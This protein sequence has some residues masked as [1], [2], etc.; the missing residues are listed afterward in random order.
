MP[1]TPAFLADRL[2]VEG[3]KV[4]EFFT[5]LEPQQWNLLVYTEGEEWT[6][7]S[8][9]AHFVTAEKGFLTLFAGIRDGGPGVPENFDVDRFNTGQQARSAQF[10]PQELLAQYREIRASMVTLAASL[11]ADDLAREGRHPFLG[12][13]SLLEMIKLVYRHN[14]I[15]LRDLRKLIVS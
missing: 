14:Q 6:V 7:R 9:L 15:H 12:H 3:E 13:T 10:T 4:A 8:L 5:R 1:E 2:T 11:T